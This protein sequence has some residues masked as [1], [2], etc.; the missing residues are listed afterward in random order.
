MKINKNRLTPIVDICWWNSLTVLFFV[1]IYQVDDEDLNLSKTTT[2]TME[3]YFLLLW[4]KVIWMTTF[5]WKIDW[6]ESP[7]LF[8]M[9]IR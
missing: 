9:M 3:N 8:S 5:K 1:K 4:S 2:I 6:N 7:A